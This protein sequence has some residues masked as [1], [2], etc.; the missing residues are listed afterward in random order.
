VNPPKDTSFL[1]LINYG[2]P[3]SGDLQNTEKRHG[4]TAPPKC[5][6]REGHWELVV[7]TAILADLSHAI[8]GEREWRETEL[9]THAQ[10]KSAENMQQ[11]AIYLDHNE[12]VVVSMLSSQIVYMAC[13]AAKLQPTGSQTES[14]CALFD[15][16]INFIIYMSFKLHE[17]QRRLTSAVFS[18]YIQNHPA[19]D[20]GKGL[21]FQR[22]TPEAMRF[23]TTTY[24]Y[25]VSYAPAVPYFAGHSLHSY[26]GP[27]RTF[28]TI[29][30]H[31]LHTELLRELGLSALIKESGGDRLSGPLDELHADFIESGP[32]KFQMS[33]HIEDHLTFR[34]DG[35]IILYNVNKFDYIVMFRNC[36]AE[37]IILISIQLSNPQSTWLT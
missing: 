1:R 31:S 23:L 3:T 7:D 9:Y 30:A 5:D 34:L 19:Y 18:K 25:V 35:Q 12:Q 22:G 28:G 11:T 17:E 36:I 27:R 6:V 26:M 2:K 32:F 15:L 16:A 20:Y 24:R 8:Y 14:L 4:L 33:D 29:R 10:G 21:I 37:Y 13:E